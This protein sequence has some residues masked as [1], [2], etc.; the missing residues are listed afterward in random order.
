MKI[1][2]FAAAATLAGMTLAG[3]SETQ[4]EPAEAQQQSDL[5]MEFTDARLVLPPV[6]GNPAAIY[7]DLAYDGERS[8]TLRAVSVAGAERAELHETSEWNGQMVMGEMGPLLLNPGD[9]VTFEPGGRHVM[10]FGVPENMT[11]GQTVEVTMT[12][13]GGDKASFEAQVVA[14]S[15][16]R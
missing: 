5:G 16:D 6:A 9:E 4:P 14:A 7:F 2:A 11:P 10:V 15:D 3:C 13:V 8:T 12:V 1:R